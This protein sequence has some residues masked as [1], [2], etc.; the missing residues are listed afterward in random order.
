MKAIKRVQRWCLNPSFYA[1]AFLRRTIAGYKN[2]TAS[3]RSLLRR[4]SAEWLSVTEQQY[5]GISRPAAE[6]ETGRLTSAGVQGGDRMTPLYHNYGA[7]YARFLRPFLLREDDLIIVE[8]GILNGTGL[9]IWR[10]LFPQARIIGFDLD[11]SNYHANLPCLLERGAF[12]SGLP[13]VFKLDQFD[14]PGG[15]R[16]LCE[17]LKGKRIDIAIDDGEHSLAA[18]RNTAKMILPNMAEEFVYFAEDNYDATRALRVDFPAVNWSHR[19]QL[20]V[21]RPR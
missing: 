20:T 8:V 14:V 15:V 19:G 6:V 16:I 4:G 2:L 3:D 12:F 17:V 7:C 18:I 9:A 11:L 21:G 1:A 10:D 5:G 13:E